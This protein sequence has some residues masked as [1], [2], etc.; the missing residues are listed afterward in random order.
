MVGLNTGGTCQCYGIG[1]RQFLACTCLWCL[2]HTL[3]INEIICSACFVGK[4][5]R[6]RCVLLRVRFTVSESPAVSL[7]YIAFKA[8]KFQ[9]LRAAAR[10]FSVDHRRLSERAKGIPFSL[11][12]TSTLRKLTSTE[13]QTI[14]RYILNLDAR[15]FAPHL[16]EVA[17]MADRMLAKRDAEPVGKNWASRFC[18]AFIWAQIGLQSS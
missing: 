9:S 12:T 10:S 16:P 3:R 1:K 14:I 8:D 18:N 6:C 5:D 15:G 7:A 11:D 13:E 17:N 2:H 4:T